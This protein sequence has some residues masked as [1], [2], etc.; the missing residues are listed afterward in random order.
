MYS[1]S[2]DYLTALS[3]PVKR[4][5]LSGSVGSVSFTQA[6][7][8]SGSLQ[9]TNKCSE[10]SEIK[11][12]SVYTGQ[13]KVTFTGL[14]IARGSWNGKVITLS[15]GLQLAD[16]SYEDV[17]LGVF[18][19]SK[20]NHTTQGVEV[21]AYDAM[22]AFDKSVSFD[23]TTGT[24]YELLDYICTQRNITLENT[25]ASIEAMPNG[26][27][28]FEIYPENDIETFRDLLFWI[29][30]SLG[31][32][33]TIN[34][35]GH[36][37]IRQYSTTSAA[38]IDESQR[39]AGC[40]FSDFVTKYTGMSVVDIAEQYTRYFAVNP[41]DG[42]TYNLG[43][44]PLLQFD[45]PL[46]QNIIDAFSAV[47][48][49]PFKASM[50]GGAIYDL[51][52]CLTF[53]GGIA[54]GAVC[55]VMAYSYKYNGSYEIE[56]FG[57]N[58][59]LANAR[60]KTD[61]DI[62]GLMSTVSGESVVHFTYTNAE[63]VSVTDGGAEQEIIHYHIY[64]SGAT[65]F[66]LNAEIKY[67]GSTTETVGT[68][69]V[70]NDLT[71][72]AK[73]Y[74]NEELVGYT[75]VET[76]QDGV[77]LLHL[78]KTFSV[79][80][81]GVTLSVTLSC[82]GGSASVSAGD[83][84]AL[85]WGQKI[86]ANKIVNI[87]V[88]TLPQNNFN[89]GIFN[90]DGLVINGVYT[91][92]TTENITS[93]CTLTPSAGTSISG[94][95]TEISAS[96]SYTSPNLEDFSVDFDIPVNPLFKVYGQKNG[97][98]LASVSIPDEIRTVGA[99]NLCIWESTY[100]QNNLKY[101]NVGYKNIV[102][103]ADGNPTYSTIDSYWRPSFTPR[104]A[105]E[106]NID[107]IKVGTKYYADAGTSEID[108]VEWFDLSDFSSGTITPTIHDPG[109]YSDSIEYIRV[110]SNAYM[111]KY[112]DGYIVYPKLDVKVTGVG[113]LQSGIGYGVIGE[114]TVDI[115]V[116]KTSSPDVSG[117]W[118]D[119]VRARFSG[120]SLI[121]EKATFDTTNYLTYSNL[122]TVPSAGAYV[123]SGSGKM[124]CPNLILYIV[125]NSKKVVVNTST[126]AYKVYAT[127][128][129]GYDQIQ[130]RTSYDS[131]QDIYITM[132]RDT[133]AQY[134]YRSHQLWFSYNLEEWYL[135]GYVAPVGDKA[136]F[137]LNDSSYLVAS[138]DYFVGAVDALQDGTMA[139]S[140][141][142]MTEIGE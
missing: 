92:G 131:E 74:L 67:T 57:E 8:V 4:F 135:G 9:I 84:N 7:V 68:T 100:Y 27:E 51:G 25:Q 16:E 13:L 97:N 132:M 37:E 17:P 91:D 86:E 90:Y 29:V 96:A 64:A 80:S 72:T 31:A 134:T 116:V 47:E 71:V 102:L 128:D 41:D 112:V 45:I 124:G 20:A 117:Y 24:A 109:T 53:S 39:F 73:Y 1:V 70:E 93:D 63:N 65:W 26:T 49:T 141:E 11:I 113:T 44:N 85:L 81:G 82:S 76:E 88:A 50:L 107:V 137:D 133:T 3:A 142:F 101:L 130:L 38:T 140:V 14:N 23:T 19:V 125:D 75:S 18:I 10:G 89:Y 61:H 35:S 121:V 48:L 118:F 129:D 126:G 66:A 43:S 12:G 77:H 54:Q 103:D 95:A 104:T 99:N 2:A 60:S 22:T 36:L 106:H 123:Y 122:C 56:G 115:Y 6:N 111:A 42:L 136:N 5:R 33:A 52:D 21:T 114:G 119:D 62:S 34:R 139:F 58:P 28:E 94:D 120:G 15:E 40:S 46:V 78:D 127:T 98:L 83:G 59:A 32:I 30:Q 55:G 69:Y 87:V 79:P 105:N 138:G 108:K 110:N